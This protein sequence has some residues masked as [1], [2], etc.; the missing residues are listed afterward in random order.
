MTTV[1]PINH[2]VTIDV[3]GFVINVFINVNHI[4]TIATAFVINAFFS[5]IL[6]AI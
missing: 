1:T 6:L 3:T 2:I 5:F 4:V